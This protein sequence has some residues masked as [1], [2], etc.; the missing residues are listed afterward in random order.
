M[1]NR[2]ECRGIAGLLPAAIIAFR[3]ALLALML[4]LP[5][6]ASA[7]N[8]EGGKPAPVVVAPDVLAPVLGK[9][10]LILSLASYDQL[11]SDFLYLA[12]LAGQDDAAEQLDRLIEAQ[13]GDRGLAAIDRNKR[14]GAYG[15]IGPNGDDSS[16]VLLVPLAD[17]NAFLNLLENFN[18]T[19][20]R[21]GDGVYS[22]AVER[23]PDPV[24]F[25]FANGYAYVTARDR[26]VLDEDRLLSP[27]AVLAEQ[28]CA[29]ATD[30]DQKSGNLADYPGKG[31]QADQFCPHVELS[32][33]VNID[34]IPT[35]FKDLALGE[36]DLQLDDARER[37]APRFETEWQRKIRLATIDEIASAIKTL[38]YEGGE[39]SLRVDLD[40]KAGDAALTVSVEGKAGS[41]MAAAIQE[42]G[43]IRSTTAGLLSKDAAVNG[44]M[45][46]SLPEKLRERFVA[47]IDD[48]RR[49][50]LAKARDRTERTALTTTFDAFMPTLKAAEL[51]W[52]FSLQDSGNDGLY[53]FIGG[54]KVRD[55]ARLERVFRETPPKDPTIEVRLDVKKVGPVGIHRVT[56]KMDDDVRRVFGDSPVYLAFRND[57]VL[58]T[59][60]ARGLALIEEALA[61]APATGKVMQLQV[62]ASRLAPLAKQRV[63]QEIARRVFGDDVDG[64]RLRLTLEGGKALTLRLSMTTK[65]IEYTSRI[66]QAMK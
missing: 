4:F 57:A 62:A 10:A 6:V 1:N 21:D 66:G 27:R 29:G 46:F 32:L 18:I 40:R 31:N 59:V 25:R 61:V 47:M 43:Q 49:Q 37:N 12:R 41:A 38:L 60:G 26:S 13:T 20:T 52:T 24:Y 34:R 58:F 2:S 63:A 28:G 42:L 65:L 50:A 19:A 9:P 11:R 5:A 45:S 3:L 55:G 54:L 44:E 23:V 14:M 22:A 48:G 15:W 30:A 16:V 33:I 39:T 17:K 64:D 53:T 35:E 56:L 8:Q 51:D 7:D 36:L